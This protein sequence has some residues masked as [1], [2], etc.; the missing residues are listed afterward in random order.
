MKVSAEDACLSAL[1]P[2]AKAHA[3]AEK[4]LRASGVK[5][6]MLRPSAFMQNFLQ[7]AP[8]IRKGFLPLPAGRGTLAWVH[9][10]D[11][12]SVAAR[13]LLDGGHDQQT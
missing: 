1:V 2:W 3:I 4:E 8:P 6:T 11:V 12:A 5:T 7:M 10:H 9:A 13:V